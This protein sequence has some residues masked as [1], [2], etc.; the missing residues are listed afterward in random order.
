MN[1]TVVRDAS[2]EARAFNLLGRAA[3]KY[4]RERQAA[5]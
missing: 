1:N 4:L 3:E 2:G 5:A